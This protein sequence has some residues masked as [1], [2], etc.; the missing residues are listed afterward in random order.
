MTEQASQK[1]NRLLPL[2]ALAIAALLLG[3]VLASLIKPAAKQA[4]AGITSIGGNFT[5]QSDKGPVSLS[6]LKGKVVP[7]YFGFASCPDVCPTSL[8]L[9]AGAIRQLDEQEQQQIQPVFISVDPGRDTPE[10]LAKYAN[11]FYP[12]ML[13]LTD[14]KEV[15]DDVTWSYRSLYK[16]VPME[17]SAMGYTVD[18]SSIIYVIGKNGIIQSLAQHGTTPQELVQKLRDALANT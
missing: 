7:L 8:G 6:D 1:T 16:I 4:P 5:L 13:G 18:H 15:I 9:L 3:V 2:A 10:K 14:K 11:A 12:G 17:D